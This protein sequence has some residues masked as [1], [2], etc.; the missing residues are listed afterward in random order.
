MCLEEEL[1][2]TVMRY[3]FKIAAILTLMTLSCCKWRTYPEADF[4]CQ[5][6][7]IQ[8]ISIQEKTTVFNSEKNCILVK[9]YIYYAYEWPCPPTEHNETCPKDFILVHTYKD[10]SVK[11]Y[12][13]S[14]CMQIWVKESEQFKINKQYTFSI[15]REGA[16]INIGTEDEE[17]AYFN[18]L[19]GYSLG[20]HE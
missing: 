18:E 3:F 4:N 12:S 19:L 8:S 1:Y 7:S 11:A 5:A 10:Y 14:E 6:V 9:G 17:M 16:L 20:T 15:K 2:K 13:P